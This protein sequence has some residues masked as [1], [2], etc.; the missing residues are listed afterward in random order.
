MRILEACIAHLKDTMETMAD[1]RTGKNLQ[2]T[3]ADIGLAAFSLFFMQRPSFL[4]FQRA[5][6]KHLGRDNTMSLFQMNKIPSDNHIRKLLDGVNPSHF[7]GEFFNIVNQ[8]IENKSVLIKNVLNN[9]TLIALDGT[10]YF[11]S[12][13]I[14]CSSCSYRKRSNGEIEYFHSALCATI[15][16]PHC[17]LTCNLPPEFVT[18]Q[19]GSTKQDCEYNAALRWMSRI[20]SRCTNLNPIYLGDDLYAKNELCKCILDMNGNFIFTCRDTSHKTLCEFRKNL[21]LSTKEEYRGKGVQKRKYIYN[22][23]TDLPIKDGKDVIKVNWIEIIISRTDGK[24]TYRNSFITNMMP[25]LDNISDLL[26]CAR[27]R[28]KIEN[29]TFNV[30]KN[31]GYNLEHNFGH[32]KRT[33]A[34]VLVILNLLAFAL[35]N[36]ADEMEYLWK[37]AREAC[38]TRYQFF[39]DFGALSCRLLLSGWD[40]LMKMLIDDSVPEAP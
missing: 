26:D 19:D 30:L 31:N 3:M 39:N 34:S 14:K 25:T 32:G 33:L 27:A 29:K 4:S 37:K 35:H 5:M 20:G 12:N 22:F 10:E 38:E 17:N 11:C 40:F 7:D 24:I 2:Y 36:L 23:I 6:K 16:K 18:P 21:R 15:V 13:K 8:L 28:W 9:H 1:P